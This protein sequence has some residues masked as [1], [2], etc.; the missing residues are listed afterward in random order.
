MYGSSLA[1]RFDPRRRRR[2]AAA[3]GVVQGRCNKLR[4]TDEEVE[5]AGSNIVWRK[6]K[7]IDHHND[8][9]NAEYLDAICRSVSLK[10]LNHVPANGAR[11]LES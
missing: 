5:D 7:G 6:G 10:M 1:Y 2:S 11:D 4:A 8:V 9:D 3:A